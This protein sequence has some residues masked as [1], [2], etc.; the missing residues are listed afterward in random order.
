MKF[1]Q[2]D[3]LVESREKLQRFFDVPICDDFAPVCL[4][5][6]LFEKG[7]VVVETLQSLFAS[8][9]YTLKTCLQ[10]GIMRADTFVGCTYE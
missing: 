6:E 5:S 1:G 3:I 4:V 8:L 10:T 2:R 7:P 9:P